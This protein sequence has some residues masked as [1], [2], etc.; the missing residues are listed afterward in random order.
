MAKVMILHN[1][2]FVQCYNP[3]CCLII[4]TINQLLTLLPLARKH[5]TP[6]FS[7][8]DWFKSKSIHGWSLLP[9][10]NFSCIE[11]VQLRH[12][13]AGNLQLMVHTCQ[14]SYSL[15]VCQVYELWRWREAEVD[16]GSPRRWV[17]ACDIMMWTQFAEVDAVFTRMTCTLVHSQG[18]PIY[19]IFYLS[20]HVWSR[21]VGG[22]RF[23]GHYWKRFVL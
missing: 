5:A 14:I 18:S 11:S 17:P 21:D 10:I 8:V 9:T 19:L 22:P 23:S 2:A 13:F 1:A 20:D 15:F 6:D 7:F 3:T 16:W 4:E 12:A